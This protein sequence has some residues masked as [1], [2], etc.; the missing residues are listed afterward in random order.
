[1]FTNRKAP[2]SQGKKAGLFYCTSERGVML[3]K[4]NCTEGDDDGK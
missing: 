3:R 2:Q 4:H 1:M